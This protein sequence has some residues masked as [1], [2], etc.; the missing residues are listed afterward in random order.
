MFEC[1]DTIT[2]E[3]LLLNDCLNNKELKQHGYDENIN[4][5]YDENFIGN[6]F[7]SENFL[8]KILSL[9]WI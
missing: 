8:K 9:F 4:G 1:N 6:S 2:D 5:F 7:N 3:E